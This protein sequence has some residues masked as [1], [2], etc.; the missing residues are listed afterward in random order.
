ML[1]GGGASWH[2]PARRAEYML[3]MP[4]MAAPWLPLL[5]AIVTPLRQSFRQSLYD[6][7]IFTARLLD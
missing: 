4:L 2:A 3:L 5:L 1:P 6:A 7:A